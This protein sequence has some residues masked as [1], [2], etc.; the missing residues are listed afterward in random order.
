MA[1]M[2]HFVRS[3]PHE[4]STKTE[5]GKELWS[6]ENK[7]DY[8]PKANPFPMM[9]Y[10]AFE[11]NGI[12][13]CMDQYPKPWTITNPDMY[14]AACE[15]V[16]NFNRSCQLTVSDETEYKKALHEGWREGPTEAYDHAMK[17]HDAV[18]H[19]VSE[20]NYQDRNMSEK[21]KAEIAA[22]EAATPRLVP[23]IPEKPTKAVKGYK[24]W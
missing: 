9:M 11:V 8:N 5:L 10:K 23:E 16:D 15:S 13:K 12:V 19:A 2:P 22:A 20:R 14:R 7:G 24:S 4:I 1:A 18:A 3:G 21:A 17:L 6:F